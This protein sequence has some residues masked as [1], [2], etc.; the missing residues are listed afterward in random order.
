MGGEQSDLPPLVAQ[1][2]S[3][4]V[5]KLPI[6]ESLDDPRAGVQRFAVPYGNI[7]I[8]AFFKRP[9]AVSNAQMFGGVKSDSF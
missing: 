8:F 5:N 3:P 2:T 4:S 6:D 9:Y 7:G 1:H